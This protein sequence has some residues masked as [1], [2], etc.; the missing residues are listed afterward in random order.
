M[1]RNRY[2]RVVFGG[3]SPRTFVSVLVSHPAIWAARRDDI[4]E[5]APRSGRGT[6]R[7][8][9]NG[10]RRRGVP[11]PEPIRVRR[12]WN[13]A[14]GPF[15]GL[16]RGL[17][18]QG[19]RGRPASTRRHDRGTK[20]KTNAIEVVTPMKSRI[21]SLLSLCLMA[22]GLVLPAPRVH[23]NA[24]DTKIALTAPADA[25]G[26]KG[27]AK[28]R[29][30]GGEQE[31]QVEVE[32]ARRLVGAVYQVFVDDAV[33][34]QVTIDAFGKGRLSLNSKRGATVPVVRKGTTVRV[35]GGDA[36]TVVA[37]SF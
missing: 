4:P 15:P 23:A 17:H 34:G 10:F 20:T 16:A 13:P 26:A 32:V 7:A 6:V 19:A 24:A 14:L 37:G 2:I 35:V 21:V 36:I 33:V 9:R 3:D 31:L 1:G 5:M 28:Y 29:N 25:R 11:E 18:W 27:A 12:A 22:V 8:P 30:R